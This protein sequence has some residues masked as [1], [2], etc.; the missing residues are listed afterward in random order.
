MATIEQADNVDH[1]AHYADKSIEV[2][3]YIEDTL[4]PDG[5]IG[6]YEGNIIKYISRWRKK[7]G[8]EDLK[9]A[10]WYLDRLISTQESKE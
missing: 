7:N 4:S 1:P 9:K 2:I 3:D 8:V 5:L 10:R 6:Y